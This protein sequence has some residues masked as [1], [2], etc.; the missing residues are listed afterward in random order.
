MLGGVMALL[1][2]GVA[3][4]DV[5]AATALGLVAGLAIV[6]AAVDAGVLGVSPPFFLRQVNEDWLGRYRAWVYGSGFGWQVG[7]GVTT[8]IMTAAVFL[9]I[10]M[11]ALTAGPIAALSLGILFGLVRGLA[12]LLTSRLHTTAQLFEFHRRFD[13]LGEP[14]RRA[15]I[16]VQLAVAIVAIG[17]AFGVVAA[18]VATAVAL[19]PV[20]ARRPARPPHHVGRPDPHFW[21]RCRA[22]WSSDAKTSEH[23]VAGGTELVGGAEPGGL[24]DHGGDDVIEAG[25]VDADLRQVRR[26]LQPGEQRTDGFGERR[27]RHVVAPAH[28]ALQRDLARAGVGLWYRMPGSSATQD[29]TPCGTS[30]TAPSE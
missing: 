30:S 18:L 11:G 14:V 16:V 13:A 23:R 20:A 2:A 26:H 5:T 15:V 29:P 4:F 17:A 27:V 8:Y 7:A 1:A 10:A 12:V 19:V 9:T 6:G 21:R 28:H 22:M 24:V 25:A 3:A